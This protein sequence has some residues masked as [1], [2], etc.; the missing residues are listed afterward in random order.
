[1]IREYFEAFGFGLLWTVMCV[2]GAIITVMF[3]F[4]LF[5][6]IIKLLAEAI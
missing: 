4:A 1:M 3:Y 2:G 5:Y 6:F